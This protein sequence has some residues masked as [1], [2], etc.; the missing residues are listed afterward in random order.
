MVTAFRKVS[1]YISG[2]KNVHTTNAVHNNI[3][4]IDFTHNRFL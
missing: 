3:V 1:A 2:Y 4:I